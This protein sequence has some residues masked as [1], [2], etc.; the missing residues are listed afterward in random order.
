[1]ICYNKTWLTNLLFLNEVE[2]DHHDGLISDTE[3]DN[4]KQKYS[5]GFYIPHF[6]IRIGLFV[7][8]LVISTFSSGLLSVIMMEAKIVDSYG[9]LIFLGV[10]NYLALEIMVRDKHHFRSGVDDGFLWISG[11]LLAVALFWAFST[12]NKVNYSA[13]SASVFLLSL[14]LTI[15][16]SD[17]L[18][19]LVAYLSCFAFVFFAWQKVGSFGTATM[20]FILLIFSA[21]FY[22]AV[23]RNLINSKAFFYSNCIMVLQVI[24]LVTIYLS[25][26]YY[27]V[28]ELGDMLNGTISKFI[29]FGWF[30]WIW[31]ITLPIVYIALGIKNK[32]VIRLRTGLLLI[33]IAAL[34]FRNYYHLMPIELTLILCGSV[35]LAISYGLIRYLSTPK[36]GFTYQEANTADLMDKANVESLI[37]SESFSESLAPASEPSSTFGGG[38][39]GGGGASS[40]F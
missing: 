4:I 22:W 1:M 33:V 25:C 3:L 39:F 26:N 8:T 13:I 32:D 30:F 6:F 9:W 20:P 11:T 15:R 10:A 16:F 5:V 14:F 7:L 28:K 36:H 35:A 34:T 19:S 18:M 17:M 27:I 29:P 40:N 21:S 23:K 2:Q 37:I 31:T 12:D 24:S 38:S